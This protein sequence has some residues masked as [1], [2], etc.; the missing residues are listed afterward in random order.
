MVVEVCKGIHN[1]TPY[2]PP[3][4][5][6]ILLPFHLQWDALK[7][8]LGILFIWI[9]K[10]LQILEKKTTSFHWK[11]KLQ[12]EIKNNYKFSMVS[13]MSFM[14]WAW[15]CWLRIEVCRCRTSPKPIGNPRAT[16]GVVVLELDPASSSTQSVTCPTSCSTIMLCMMMHAYMTS[17][18]TCTRNAPDL[19]R[20]PTAI[21]AP[22][23][24]APHP[25]ARTAALPQTR[26]CSHQLG[27]WSS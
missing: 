15:S 20:L 5:Y 21:G 27:S 4:Q 26:L 17:A 25:S 6:F 11:F 14:S 13:I 2:A 3:R 10:T 1:G 23:K 16:G 12:Y 8:A 24:P 9:F 22:Q 18:M 19:L 7:S